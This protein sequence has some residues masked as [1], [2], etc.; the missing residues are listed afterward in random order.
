MCSLLWILSIFTIFVADVRT[1]QQKDLS[2]RRCHHCAHNARCELDSSPVVCPAGQP[3]CATVASAPNFTSTLTCATASESPCSLIYNSK[4]ALEITCIC[5]DHLCNAPYSFQFRNELLNFSTQIPA[6]TSTELTETFLKSSFFTN[7]TKTEL[8]ETITIVKAMKEKNTPF[9]SAQSTTIGL[10]SIGAAE[11]IP[12]RAEALKN[13]ATVPPDDDEDE[14]E[15]S[16]N[17]EETKSQA[18]APAAPSS[19]LPAEENKVAP[20]II[21][22]YLLASSIFFS[23]C[24]IVKII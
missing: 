20:V 5:D 1:L 3:L 18:A 10:T 4:L 11:D 13:E 7:V 6:N 21:N 22:T 17:F 9:F 15:G 8:Y 24:D 12:P 23:T 14:V 19:Y 16:G 2:P